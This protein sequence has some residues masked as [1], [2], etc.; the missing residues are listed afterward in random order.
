MFDTFTAAGLI[1][2]ASTFVAELVT[3][4]LVVAGLGIALGLT[5]WVVSKLR[6][7]AR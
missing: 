6:R 1:T 7:A 5:G 2:Q 4:A 3:P